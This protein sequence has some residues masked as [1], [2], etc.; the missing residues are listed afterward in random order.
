M[1][2]FGWSP[3]TLLNQGSTVHVWLLNYSYLGLKTAFA[4]GKRT[5]REK[6]Y[7]LKNMRPCINKN[8]SGTLSK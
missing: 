1:N 5:K 4:P 2:K 3:A 6:F 8:T 7:K